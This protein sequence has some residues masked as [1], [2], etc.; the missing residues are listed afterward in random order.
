ML[1]SLHGI[2]EKRDGLHAN[3]RTLNHPVRAHWRLATAAH[4]AQKRT[5]GGH[6]S[7]GIEMIQSLG[8]LGNATIILAN[9]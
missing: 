1:R 7:E 4:T 3:R 2:S 6:G 5:L 8:D 9:L